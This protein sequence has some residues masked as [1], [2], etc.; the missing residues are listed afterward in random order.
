MWEEKCFGIL[1]AS[2]DDGY[3][4]L[5]L[6]HSFCLHCSPSA[7]LLVTSVQCSEEVHKLKDSQCGREISQG[8]SMMVSSSFLF[9]KEVS[10]SDFTG[11]FQLHGSSCSLGKGDLRGFSYIFARASLRYTNLTNQM[12]FS[13][14]AIWRKGKFNLFSKFILEDPI[15]NSFPSRCRFHQL[16]LKF[17]SSSEL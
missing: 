4:Q 8:I 15:E 14:L 7:S 16:H 11:M 17:C 10:F 6:L 5:H 12:F 1:L 9:Q 13:F 2:K 3:T